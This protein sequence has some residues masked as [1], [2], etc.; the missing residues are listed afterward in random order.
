MLRRSDIQRLA[1]IGKVQFRYAPG[2]FGALVVGAFFIHRRETGKAL[3]LAAVAE[4]DVAAQ[5]VRGHG[6]V[7]GRRHLAG[8]ET[9]VDQPVKLI[10]VAGQRRFDSVRR[11]REHA[12]TDR[13]V[14]VLSALARPIYVGRFGQVFR[15]IV[16]RDV[17]P[18]F[19]D[20]IVGDAGGVGT[21]VCHKAYRAFTLDLNAFVEL[22]GDLHGL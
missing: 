22:L 2:L 20:R 17:V 4:D 8:H 5:Y 15:R 21:D 9:V 14:G 13:L 6:V 11:E 16:A 19:C 7:G 12:G 1:R 10:L 3:F 18:D